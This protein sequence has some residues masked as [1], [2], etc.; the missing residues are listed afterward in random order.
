MEL[1][2]NNSNGTP[3]SGNQ[4]CTKTFQQLAGN[5]SNSK[6]QVL[7]LSSLKNLKFNKRY[8]KI[9]SQK[10]GIFQTSDMNSVMDDFIKGEAKSNM[11]QRSSISM[12]LASCSPMAN[13]TKNSL[14]L[15]QGF[16]SRGDSRSKVSIFDFADTG[17]GKDGGS[18]MRIAEAKYNPKLNSQ[19]AGKALFSIIPPPE[20][21]KLM[22]TLAE[23]MNKDSPR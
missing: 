10:S 6:Q 19:L 7:S 15:D 3:K 18:L 8:N 9:V 11:K 1:Q 20:L 2:A 17:S 21:P 14:G 5:C 4:N 16:Q 23:D 22:V 13:I 12:V